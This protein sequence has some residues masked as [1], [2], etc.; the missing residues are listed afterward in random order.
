MFYATIFCKSFYRD[1]V[2]YHALSEEADPGLYQVWSLFFWGSCNRVVS[3]V[4]WKQFNTGSN[5]VPIETFA[6]YGHM[7]HLSV[8][9]LLKSQKKSLKKSYIGTLHDLDVYRRYKW[10]SHRL[11][12]RYITDIQNFICIHRCTHTYARDIYTKW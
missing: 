5:P 8:I 11:L 2:R 10:Y 3:A 12:M 4:D 1:R 7:D 9:N 6:K